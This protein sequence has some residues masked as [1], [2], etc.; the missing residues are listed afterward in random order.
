[1]F[2]HLEFLDHHSRGSSLLHSLDARVKVGFVL[3]FILAA[4]TTPIGRYWDLLGLSAILFPLLFLTRVAPA[5]LAGKIA[6]ILPV[7][8]VISIGLPFMAG[9][10]TVLRWSIPGIDFRVT[11]EGIHLFLTVFWKAC[12]A[13]GAVV[14]LNVSTPFPSVLMVL[15]TFRVPKVFVAM[16]AVMYRYLFVVFSE[17]D[18]LL[19]ARSSRMT[20]PTWWV[21]WK[22][23][24][25]VA[26]VLFVRVL[27]R[28]ERIH[29]AMRSR[30]FDGT[31]VALAEFRARPL[32]WLAFLLGVYLIA[33]VKYIGIFHV[34]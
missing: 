21:S 16:L 3:L 34:R 33:F 2:A 30:G 1:M 24:A 28:G 7:I 23:L 32:D 5:H 20:R 4:A 29:E 13:V 14:F 6:K 18:R 26:G 17:A 19:T 25:Q 31:A 9:G 22:S 8:L 12:L 11:R 15:R 10:E 27:G